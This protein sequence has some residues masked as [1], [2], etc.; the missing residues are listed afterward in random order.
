MIVKTY[1]KWV[2]KPERAC[3]V[4]ILSNHGPFTALKKWVLLNHSPFR[5][6][7]FFFANF[8]KYLV[9]KCETAGML[10]PPLTI[11]P[12][13]TTANTNDKIHLFFPTFSKI[14]LH[15]SFYFLSYVI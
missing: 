4:R 13:S 11:L 8:L 5:F 12:I 14:V 1:Q 7:N 9:E 6:I 2:K 10:L 3:N 15:I